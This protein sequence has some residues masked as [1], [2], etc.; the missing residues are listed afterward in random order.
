MTPIDRCL[1][2]L[3]KLLLVLHA[4][5][6]VGLGMAIF[7]A[8]QGDFA[9]GSAF[10]AFSFLCHKFEGWCRRD[11]NRIVAMVNEQNERQRDHYHALLGA[12]RRGRALD[13]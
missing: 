6:G 7:C 2:R 11:Y 10:A 1:S 8:V 5:G 13:R 3:R 4:L 12:R 9:A